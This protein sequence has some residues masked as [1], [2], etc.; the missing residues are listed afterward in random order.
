MTEHIINDNASIYLS[1]L[2]LTLTGEVLYLDQADHLQIE[3][4][5][6]VEALSIQVAALPI[7]AEG[8]VYV[9][10]YSEHTGM[11]QALLDAGVATAISSP[12]GIGPFDATV[13]EVTLAI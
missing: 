2:D 13:R 12:I 11:P 1:N 10:D 6:G 8:R 4:E 5:E 9:R 7:P 3:T